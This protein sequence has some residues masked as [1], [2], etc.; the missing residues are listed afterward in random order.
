MFL[1]ILKFC[2]DHPTGRTVNI[3]DQTDPIFNLPLK[4]KELRDECYCQIMKQ[5]TRN[6]KKNSEARVWKLFWLL[7]GLMPPS[8]QLYPHV[9]RFLSSRSENAMAMEC[10]QRVYR[11]RIDFY[12]Y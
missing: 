8:A 6:P 3:T 7:C 2:G 4:K 11:F 12:I 9:S 5:L 1:A 10:S